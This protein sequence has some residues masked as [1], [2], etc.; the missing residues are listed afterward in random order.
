M[1]WIELEQAARFAAVDAAPLRPTSPSR[2][3]FV[4][5]LSS[6]VRLHAVD[7]PSL[8]VSRC[9]ISRKI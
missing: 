2:P 9:L 4:M 5:I 7:V 3:S 1:N 8:F 6:L